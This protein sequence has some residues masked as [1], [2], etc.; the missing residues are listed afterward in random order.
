MEILKLELNI[1]DNLKQVFCEKD[2]T[3]V[4]FKILGGD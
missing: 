1:E 4:N 3:Y 2:K